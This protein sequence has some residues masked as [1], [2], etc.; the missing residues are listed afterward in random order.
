[1]ELV[2]AP[3][4]RWHQEIAVSLLAQQENVTPPLSRQTKETL[5]ALTAS[6][7]ELT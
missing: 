2:V 5:N 4:G 1:M 6:Y 3:A 7:K